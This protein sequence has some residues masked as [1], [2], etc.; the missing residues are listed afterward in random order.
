[1][2]AAHAGVSKAPRNTASR[3]RL[4][5]PLPSV[6]RPDVLGEGDLADRV[7]TDLGV[8]HAYQI[9]NDVGGATMKK[10]TY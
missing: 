5:R 4:Y 7:L 10:M 2:D 1:M 9:P 8:E 3:H 6:Q